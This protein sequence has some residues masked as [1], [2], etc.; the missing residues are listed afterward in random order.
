MEQLAIELQEKLKRLNKIIEGYKKLL[1]AY[2][3]GVDSTFLLKAACDVLGDGALGVIGISPSLAKR[4]LNEAIQVAEEFNL[5]YVLLQT[6]ELED[7]NYASNP[8]NRCYFCKRE[9]FSEIFQYAEANDFIHIADGT[10]LDDTGDY[11]PG[12]IA[13]KELRVVSPI[14]EAG[15]TKQDVRDISKFFGLPTW[16]KPALACL[17]SRFPTGIRVTTQTLNQVEQAEDFL[18]S[19]GFRILRVR[20]HDNLARIEVAP[21]EINRFFNTEVRQKINHRFLELGYKFVTLDLLGYRMGSLN[22]LLNV[23]DQHRSSKK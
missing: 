22:Q 23:E 9:L 6:H 10:N 3:G 8:D 17:S 21:E 5:P 12:R 11:R 13:A 1:V 18:Y 20:H 4:E 14:Q 15:L 2:S 16:N 19:L 7:E